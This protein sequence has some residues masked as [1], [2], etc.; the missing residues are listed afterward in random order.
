MEG[1]QFGTSAVTGNPNGVSV[2]NCTQLRLVLEP[3]CKELKEG[4]LQRQKPLPAG[5]LNSCKIAQAKQHALCAEPSQ[6]LTC[7]WRTAQTVNV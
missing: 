1:C 6:L 2:Y 5:D 3:P 4:Q 7:A